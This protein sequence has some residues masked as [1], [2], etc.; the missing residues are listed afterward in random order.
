MG[1]LYRLF[2]AIAIVAILTAPTVATAEDVLKLAMPHKG[3]WDTSVEDYGQRM[4][5]FEQEGLKLD[6]LY[7]AGGSEIEQAVMSGT[8]DIGIADGLLGVLAAFGK[9]VPLTIISAEC[10]GSPDLF[11]YVRADSPIKSLKDAGGK[12]MGF[13]MPGSSTN[14]VALLLVQQAGTPIKV[15]QAGDTPATLTEVMSGQIDIGWSLV[16]FAFDQIDAGKIRIVA[17]GSDLPEIAHQTVRVNFALADTVKNKHD[18]LVRFMRAYQ[19]TVDW[20]YSGDPK[21]VQWLAEDAHVTVDEAARVPTE[22]FPKT[23]LRIAPVDGLDLTIKQ[24][25]ETKRLSGPLTKEQ[26]ANLMDIVYTPPQN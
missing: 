19:R 12:T 6:L 26:I 15:T 22:F 21:A 2:A 4:G 16:P 5:F 10:T 8:A 25:I 9:G 24:A 20:L 23:A 18:Q 13:S 11:W 1:R 14:L 3:G 17:R 7:T